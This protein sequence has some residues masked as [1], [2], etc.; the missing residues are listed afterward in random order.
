MSDGRS[1][2]DH[3]PGYQPLAP[4]RNGRIFAS[5]RKVRLGDVDPSGR[6]RLDALT[7]YCQDVS[8]DDTTEAGL[9]DEPG[10]VVRSTVVDELEPA[11]LYEPLSFRTFCSGL[12]KRWA[13]RRLEVRGKCGARYEVATLWVCVDTENGQPR[14]LTSQFLDLYA[15]AADGRTASARLRNPKP[16]AVSD[17]PS[18]HHHWQLRRVDFDPLDHV[19]NAAYWAAV[20][21][22]MEPFRHPRRIRM[23]YADGI[24]ERPELV[25][26]RVS[27]PDHM[28]LW[29][30]AGDD[31]PSASASVQPASE[32]S[33]I[34]A[35]SADFTGSVPSRPGTD[36]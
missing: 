20:E 7:R 2:Q 29:W 23:E 8:N 34:E 25:I 3:I 35:D 33:V 12:G 19:N 14:R 13:E 32:Q 5:E 4:P 1:L 21:E 36:D 6:L 28:M 31:G 16:G 9:D 11:R 10:W 24:T 26:E 15:E 18:R 17:Q 30:W 22:W 27:E